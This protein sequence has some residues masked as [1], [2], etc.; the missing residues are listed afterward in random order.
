MSA[1]THVYCHYGFQLFM[2]YIAAA[3]AAFS[4][5]NFVITC[6]DADI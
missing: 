3:I 5:V 4:V 2:F 1:P 6:D